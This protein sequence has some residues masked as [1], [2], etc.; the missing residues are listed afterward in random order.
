MKFNFKNFLAENEGNIISSITILLLFSFILVGILVLQT[1][2]YT[3]DNKVSKLSN[4]N[5]EYIVEN[6]RANI[7]VLSLDIINQTSINIIE[8][9]Q[10]L[11]NSRL[12]LKNRIN[13]RLVDENRKYYNDYNIIINSEVL[14]V[15]SDD[16]PFYIN[17]KTKLT[18]TKDE[19]SYST[20]DISKISVIGLYDPLPFLK[21]NGLQMENDKINY[22]HGL[23]DYLDRKIIGNINTNPYINGKSPLFI[24]KCPYEPYNCHG[25]NNLC[26]NCLLN[27]Y[28][29]ESNDGSCYLCRMEGHGTCSHYG[30]ETFIVPG[31]YTET[32][33][34]ITSIDHVIF[35]DNP[36]SGNLICLNNS[37]NTKNF[38]FLDNGHK[39]KY[40]FSEFYEI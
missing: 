37:S 40:G 15:F 7:K 18:F 35:S 31:E 32:N 30:L 9:K 29:H 26:Q 8:S 27:G 17:V 12:E 33:S 11:S 20:E 1:S 24:K 14:E 4:D 23:K 34:S 13:Q 38:I 19:V 22:N 25:Q 36:Y 16:N 10:P 28:Y 3:N 21:C 6:Y 39:N 5:F 2:N